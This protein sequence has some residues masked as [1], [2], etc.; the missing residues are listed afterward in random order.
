MSDIWNDRN[1]RKRKWTRGWV[2]AQKNPMPDSTEPMKRARI[3]YERHTLVCSKCSLFGLKST[4]QSRVNLFCALGFKMLK[5][6]RN[7]RIVWKHQYPDAYARAVVGGV[8][9]AS[10]EE[11]KKEWHKK[12]DDAHKELNYNEPCT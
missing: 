3:E 8:L 7:L 11:R 5:K 4:A 9:H 10:E 2:E 12:S 6:Y 1:L